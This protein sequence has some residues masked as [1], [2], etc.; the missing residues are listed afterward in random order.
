VARRSTPQRAVDDRCFPIRVRF[1]LPSHGMGYL[2]G[3][4]MA[5]WLQ[6]NLLP[7]DFAQHPDS[8][9]SFR[10]AFAVYFRRVS[11]AQ[12]FVNAFPGAELADGIIST[13]YTTPALPS[14]RKM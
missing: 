10:E 11:D 5:A 2:G 9:P 1:A 4:N 7:S 6:D 12:R 8:G 3:F 14:A 13:S